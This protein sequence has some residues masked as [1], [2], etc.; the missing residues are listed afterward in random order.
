[1]CRILV[2]VLAKLHANPSVVEVVIC[3]SH[4]AQ[5][6]FIWNL[7]LALLE[8]TPNSRW[9][10]SYLDKFIWCFLPR[11]CCTFQIFNVCLHQ[12]CQ[13]TAKQRYFF[14]L[15]VFYSWCPLS[16]FSLPLNCYFSFIKASWFSPL[17]SQ[18]FHTLTK[19]KKFQRED[20]LEKSFC[21][22]QRL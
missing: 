20:S 17:P 10:F 8:M 18:P 6:V 21:C 14:Q 9:G 15:S 12:D 22:T 1:M 4:L 16:Y 5:E 11:W 2:G 13:L 7:S 3:D 19:G